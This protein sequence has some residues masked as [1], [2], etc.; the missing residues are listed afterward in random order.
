[1]MCP[2]PARSI[3]WKA[4]SPYTMAGPRGIEFEGAI[5]ALFHL[6]LTRT[7]KVEKPY[8]IPA[9]HAAC[10]GSVCRHIAGQALG[11]P[12]H[13]WALLHAMLISQAEC[14]D[15]RLGA[16][17]ARALCCGV[18]AHGPARPVLHAMVP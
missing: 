10:H 3:I 5:I 1:M 2:C 14:Q 17:R 11:G 18:H 9:P 7:D 15:R 6:L 12:L 4:F 16:C 13:L 8:K